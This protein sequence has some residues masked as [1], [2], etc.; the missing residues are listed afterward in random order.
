MCDGIYVCD[1]RSVCIHVPVRGCM[2]IHEGHVYG[3]ACICE[4]VYIGER[5][6]V[7]MCDQ[8]MCAR[9]PMYVHMYV[10]IHIN[11]YMWYTYMYESVPV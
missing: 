5:G 1:H 8:C 6:H 4:S 7:W 3:G 10:C 2:C 11:A 9:V